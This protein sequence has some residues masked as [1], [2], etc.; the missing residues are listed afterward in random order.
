MVV[1][2][3]NY[4]KEIRSFFEPINSDKL[5]AINV[6]KYIEESNQASDNFENQVYAGIN[7]MVK[8]FSFQEEERQIIKTL[9]KTFYVTNGGE[10]IRLGATSK[11]RYCLIKPTDLFGEKFNLRREMVVIFSDY[12]KFE[13]RTFDAIAEVFN[14]NKQEFRIDKVCSVIISR[15]N[16][17]CEEVSQILKS[18]AE[19][20]VVVPFSYAELYAGNKT[21][22]ITKR[23]QEFF[24]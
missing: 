10:E 19:M 14:R 17:V 23:F 12:R 13:P 4:L 15:D 5:V 18:D 22:L 24:L 8:L 6:K 1:Y 11:Y 2:G 21:T 16:N 9:A 20:Q 3:K 7:P